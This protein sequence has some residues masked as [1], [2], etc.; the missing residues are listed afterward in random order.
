[1]PQEIERKFLVRDD[2]WRAAVSQS[3]H[4]RQGYL[5][6]VGGKA[7]IRV[8]VQADEARLNIKA[9]VIGSSRAEYDYGIPLEEAT[10]ILDALSIGR[11]EK[12]RHH[13]HV[14][15]HLWEIDEFDGANRGLIVAEIELDAPDEDFEKPAWVGREVTDERQ[16]YNHALAFH[17]YCE[18]TRATGR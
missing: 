18:W 14:G 16:Y 6:G 17:P 2:G 1:M 13:V 15:G 8:R 4:I 10:E 9:A 7:S 5:N 12:T 11:V 3:R